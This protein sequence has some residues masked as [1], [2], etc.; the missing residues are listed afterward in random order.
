[1]FPLEVVLSFSMFACGVSINSVALTVGSNSAVKALFEAEKFW[2]ENSLPSLLLNV[3]GL[4]PAFSSFR[5]RFSVLGLAA[6]LSSMF[7]F[8]VSSNLG[9]F[10][11]LLSM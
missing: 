10:G 9:F 3:M 1:M 2:I 7:A 4:I 8:K 11:S 6:T 5:S